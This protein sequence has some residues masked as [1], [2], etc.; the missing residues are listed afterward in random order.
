MKNTQTVK[1]ALSDFTKGDIASIVEVLDDNIEW[2]NPEHPKY[3][4]AFRSKAGT[5]SLPF[6]KKWQILLISPGLK[7][8]TLLSRSQPL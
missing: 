8:V 1:K 3:L 4:S 6:S 2:R 5:M 7:W